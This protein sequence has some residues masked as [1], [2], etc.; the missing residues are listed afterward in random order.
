LEGNPESPHDFGFMCGK[1]NAGLID[2]YNP[3]RLTKPLR[4]T[5]PEK[6]IG[7]D[8][9][10]EEITYEEALDIIVEKMAKIRKEDPRKL[11]LSVF[12]SQSFGQIGRPWF[13]AFGT[14]NI[15]AGPAGY[16]C[17]NGYHNVTLVAHGTFFAEPDYKYCNYLLL[18]GS[19]NGFVVGTNPM[20][21]TKMTADARRR[22][23]KLVVVDPVCHHSGSKADEW[24]PIRPGTDAAFALGLLNVMLNDHGFYDREFLQKYSNGPYLVGSDEFYVRDA[25]SGKPLVWD[26]TAGKARPFNDADLGVPAIEGSFTVNGVN[27]K[28]AFEALKE[29][30]RK[31]TPEEVEK[32]TTVSADTIRRVGKEF[33]E[34]ARIGATIK[35]GGLLPM[36]MV[37]LRA[38]PFNF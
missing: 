31:Y 22:G 11:L 2:L 35:I 26:E 6:G 14:P 8:P 36:L 10:W 34:A 1:G 37:C 33:G 24:I 28:P 5:N 9:G 32:I 25:E 17:G 23:M 20:G 30:V 15:T 12:D 3:N 29:H 7:V 13:A 21:L 19:S 16:Y 18:I 4:R 38:G 27:C